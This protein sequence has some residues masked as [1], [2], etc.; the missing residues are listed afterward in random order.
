MIDLKQKKIPL[1]GP[2]YKLAFF[3]ATPCII[4]TF[5]ARIPEINRVRRIIVTNQC[6]KLE[7]D[8]FNI[9]LVIVCQK[10]SRTNGRTYERTRS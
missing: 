4:G 8:S 3:Y 7:D 9:F 2:L 5:L 10:N 1:Y 6:V